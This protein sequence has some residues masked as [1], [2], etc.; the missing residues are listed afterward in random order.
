M[1][2]QK[3]WNQFEAAILLDNYI[4]YIN[5]EISRKEAIQKTSLELRTMAQCRGYEIDDIYRNINGITFQ[6]HSME[7][8]YR[9][10]TLLKPASKLFAEMV[11]IYKQ[12]N[13]RFIK[14][15]KEARKMGSM[16]NNVGDNLNQ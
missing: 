13:K 1:S 5:G 14:I 11:Q 15:L 7:S 3:Q 8:A 16:S 2:I 9:G 12:D 6:M 10:Y 4:K